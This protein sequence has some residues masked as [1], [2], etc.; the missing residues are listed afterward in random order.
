MDLTIQ[1]RSIDLLLKLMKHDVCS[2]PAYGY[3]PQKQPLP[4]AESPKPLVRCAPEE[5]GV[6]SDALRQFFTAVNGAQDT[7]AAHGVMVLRRGKVIAEG[8]W[9]PYR[10]DVPH[11]LYSMSKSFLGT[12]VGI[13]VDEG[14]LSLDEKL[15]DIFPDLVTPNHAKLIRSMTVK[16]L[17]TMSSGCRFNEMGTLLDGN[18][19]KMFL[20]SVP[21]FE[22]GT[23]FDY[24]SLNTYMLAAVICRKTGQSVTEYLKPRL[25]A[26]LHIERFTWETCPMGIEK[27]GWGLSL[28]MED[29]AKLGQ[30][31]L[32]RGMWEG[33]RIFSEAWA[34]AAT[35]KQIDTP[36]GEMKHGYGYQIWMSDDEGGF[37]FNGAFGQYVIVSPKH[38]AVAVIFSGSANLFAQGA[39]T[40][41]LHTLFSSFKDAPLPKDAEAEAALRA[42]CRSL[43]FSPTLKGSLAADTAVFARMA[44]F[45]DGKEYRF[46]PNAGG[47]LPQTLQSVHGNFTAGADMLRFERREYGLDIRLY[48][49]EECNR[50]AVNRDGTLRYGR[51]AFRGEWHK[52][53]SRGVWKEEP[54][55]FS[56]AVLVSL[57]E[58]PNARILYI[59]VRESGITVTFDELPEL[60]RVTAMLFQLV[61]ISGLDYLKRLLGAAQKENLT[62]SLRDFAAPTAR[63]VP[64]RHNE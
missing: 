19:Q 45:L 46:L 30:L 15:V 60:S 8:T 42:Y 27:G 6:S 36:K 37:Q 54:D 14:L 26:P 18:W 55:G 13:A 57:T 4:E 64:I 53:G 16:H 48:E 38:D 12:A 17:L 31:Y 1:M 10:S 28:T 59:R 5:A 40:E 7:V 32:N 2:L 21:K 47:I 49:G 9:A 20:E 39:L 41:H 62:Q 33:K 50:I 35:E 43:L 24:N 29:A 58:T 56:L 23:A 61:G 52:T 51:I 63:G 22:P 3:R 11:M 25:F 34:K 44:A